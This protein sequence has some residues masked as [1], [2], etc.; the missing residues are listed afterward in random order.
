MNS[1]IQATTNLI[2]ALDNYKVKDGKISVQDVRNISGLFDDFEKVGANKLRT[3]YGRILVETN[4][5]ITANGIDELTKKKN[6]NCL[7]ASYKTYMR[8]G[9]QWNNKDSNKNRFFF[10]K[11]AETKFD[12]KK[13]KNA[14]IGNALNWALKKAKITSSETFTKNQKQMMNLFISKVSNWIGSDELV[15]TVS[16]VKGEFVEH[17]QTFERW[18]KL[19]IERNKETSKKTSKEKTKTTKSKTKA[20]LLSNDIERLLITFKKEKDSMKNA[21]MI[22]ALDAFF[23]AVSNQ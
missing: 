12:G 19:A 5:A 16:V 23:E 21:N 17:Q 7:I 18:K 14:R 20:E 1:E 3:T 6:H 15:T 22:T 13:G 10:G 4:C 8:N 2:T 9:S 11:I